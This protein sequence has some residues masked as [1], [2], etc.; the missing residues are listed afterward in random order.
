MP[1]VNAA[2][3]LGLTNEPDTVDPGQAIE[4]ANVY[5][6]ALLFGQGLSDALMRQVEL[7]LAAHFLCLTQR[8]GTLAA[9][10]IGESTERYHDHYSAGLMSTRF[11]QQAILFDTTGILADAAAT[12]ENPSR[13]D[14]Q[15][16]VI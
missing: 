7:Y 8:E 15:I 14:A 10:T 4:T 5:V 9:Q 2:Q 11:G 1:R 13:R 6:D 3:V 16:H 12:A